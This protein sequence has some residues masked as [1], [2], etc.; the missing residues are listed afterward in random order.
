MSLA[1]DSGRLALPREVNAQ[2]KTSALVPPALK[3]QV[4]QLVAKLL[5]QANARWGV[6]M[7]APEVAFDLRGTTA[8]MAVYPR[9]GAT[10]APRLRFNAVLLRDNAAEFFADTVP[11]EV[12]HLVNRALEAKTPGAKWDSHGPQ[13]QAV[14]RSFGVEPSRCHGLDVRA[15]RVG[16]SWRFR[17]SCR[18]F[19][20][21]KRK[22]MGLLT[23]A[24]LAEAAGA[25][26]AAGASCRK[27]G[28]S[29]VFAGIRTTEAGEERVD[30][31][32]RFTVVGGRKRLTAIGVLPAGR[33]R[34]PALVPAPTP[35]PTPTPVTRPAP[36]PAPAPRTAPP[37]TRPVVARGST[38]T[39]AG[40]ALST[41]RAL[42]S[43]PVSASTSAPA[44]APSDA[45]LSFARD[46]ARRRGLDLPEHVLRDRRAISDWIGRNR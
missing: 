27:C 14:M 12:A 10:H 18:T 26:G 31:V 20:L 29:V 11:H 39:S 16:G 17:C 34:A 40:A 37:A 41:A 44:L 25:A 22:A 38:G 4:L 8:G 28:S 21:G 1:P 15:A 32:P 30:I 23:S 2:S 33:A 42:A 3:H 36:V 9:A 13:W 5:F 43:P 24:A 46:I 7:P 45:Q 35:A 6:S 19:E